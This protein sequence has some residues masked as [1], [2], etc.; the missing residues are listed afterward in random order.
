[1]DWQGRV[2]GNKNM[3]HKPEITNGPVLTAKEAAIQAEDRYLNQMDEGFD[4]VRVYYKGPKK[5]AWKVR[6][7]NNL[8]TSFNL[9]PGGTE[10]KKSYFYINE[11]MPHNDLLIFLHTIK[12]SYVPLKVIHCEAKWGR[13][14]SARKRFLKYNKPGIDGYYRCSYCGGRIPN[15]KL[16][17]DHILSINNLTHRQTTRDLA[18]SMG[19]TRSDSPKN[20]VATCRSC[21]QKKDTKGGGWIALAAFGRTKWFWPFIKVTF[22]VFVVLLL[23]FLGYIGAF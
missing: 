4:F 9:R 8:L 6:Q 11:R 15:G 5:N 14:S 18:L 20:L 17:I 19:I 22:V 21:N 12:Q 3:I 1:M 23:A 7:Y 16:Q 2:P 13:G 10:I